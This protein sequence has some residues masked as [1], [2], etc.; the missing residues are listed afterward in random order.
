MTY[1]VIV[2]GGGLA[3]SALAI[4]LARKG[5]RVLVLEREKE[6]KDRVRGEGLL[7]WGVNEARAL[8]IYDELAGSC[9]HVVRY[10]DSHGWRAPRDLEATTP[11]AAHCLTFH[12]PEMQEILLGAAE[13]AGAQV[14]RGASIKGVEGGQ[15]PKVH[16]ANGASDEV[17]EAML[18]VGADGRASKVRNWIGFEKNNDPERLIVSGLLIEGSSIPDDAVHLFRK[19]SAGE[20]AL[21]LPARWRPSP[22]LLFLSQARRAV[23]VV[24]PVAGSTLSRT[25]SGRRRPTRV[26]RRR[27]TGWPVGRVSMVPTRG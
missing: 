26:A 20:E 23:G 16:A 22:V 11:G 8:G 1:D 3:G 19:S 10:W 15:V 17:L 5:V 18:V 24:W 12:H 4:C 7:P 25:L 14:R 6:F 21:F 2:V 13:D 27:G 9:G